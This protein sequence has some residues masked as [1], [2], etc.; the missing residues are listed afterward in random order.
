MRR[1]LLI[2]SEVGG[3]TGV[4]RDVAV[5]D[6]VLRGH[7]FS[8]VTATG[9][10][11]TAD[12]IVAQLRDLAADTADGD[13]A[14][15]YY[16][17]HG[18]RVANPAPDPGLPRWLQFVVPTDFFDRSEDRARVVLAEE[19]SRLQADL[20]GRTPNVTS[21]YDC[22]HSARMS[23][24]ATLI[25]RALDGFGLPVADLHARWRALRE[26]S[27]PVTGGVDSNP[28]AVRVVA[29]S[30][31]ESAYEMPSAKPWTASTAC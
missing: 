26:A 27:W 29:C 8:T 25:P 14:V 20:T 22:C 19:L 24:D 17:G 4:H 3:L 15:V 9:G 11:A 2:G 10:D 1:A 7:G 30:A 23:R 5:M 31:D 16:S 12:G 28:E 6:E 13:A 18:G 21:I